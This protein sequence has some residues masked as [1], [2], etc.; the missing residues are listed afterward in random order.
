M[1]LMRIYKKR[2]NNQ[3]SVILLSNISNALEGQNAID[4]VS[5]EAWNI[6]SDTQD[7][8][9]TLRATHE[10]HMS[11][12]HA[13][14][15]DTKLSL[16][17]KLEKMKRQ[18][19]T[20]A[21][22]VK[23]AQNSNDADSQYAIQDLEKQAVKLDN[24][25]KV[26]SIESHRIDLDLRESEREKRERLREDEMAAN[27]K[28]KGGLERLEDVLTKAS[29]SLEEQRNEAKSAKRQIEMQIKQELRDAIS[30]L[31]KTYANKIGEE[32]E[33]TAIQEKQIKSEI[34]HN[35]DIIISAPDE[36]ALE[37][38]K[39]ICLNGKLRF[40]VETR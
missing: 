28:L 35:N 8:R 19:K 23:K 39:A 24:E 9:R 13:M 6:V 5:D 14:A 2:I 1:I 4:D 7:E 26:S 18:R 3:R 37:L 32:E 22:Q 15:E 40:S 27:E 29:S 11:E 36:K 16:R 25:I 12:L 33:N 38:E 21:N 30:S 17:D 10:E 20:L 34:A 31:K